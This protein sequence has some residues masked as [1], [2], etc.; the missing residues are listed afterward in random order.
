MEKVTSN[1]GLLVDAD[2]TAKSL[3]EKVR[4]KRRAPLPDGYQIRARDG[5][6]VFRFL[7]R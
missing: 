4:F 7:E 1:L 6:M 2:K 3:P 5:R